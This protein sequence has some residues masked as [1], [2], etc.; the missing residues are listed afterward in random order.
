MKRRLLLVMC[1][2]AVALAGCGNLGL[3]EPDCTPP[4][5]D[6]SSA[7][8]MNVQAVPTAKYT[9]CLNGIRL[10]WDDASWFAEDG[11]AGIE[12]R[13]A[14]D[15]PF[16]TAIVTERCDVS[17]ATQVESGVP[18]ISRYEDVEFVPPEIGVTLVPGGLRPQV[19]ARA[20]V[21]QL[22]GTDLD[23]RPVVFTIDDNVAESVTSRTNLALM[24]NQYVWIIDELDVE[25]GTVELR[26]DRPPVAGR[27]ISP[28]AALELIEDH[29]PEVEYRGSWF[30]TFEGG[31]ITYSFDARGTLAESVAADAELAFGFYPASELRLGLAR[32]GYDIGSP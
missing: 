14:L 31:C 8:L 18:D 29:L 27:G 4:E 22:E 12:I 3:G 15:E 2:F 21:G 13:R 16:L 23:G 20:L 9:P 32:S 24:R 17:R 1:A 19:H 26:S 5:R 6:V 10:G 30:F 25:E 28:N 7:N 11:R